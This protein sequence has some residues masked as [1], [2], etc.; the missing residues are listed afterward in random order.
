V[1]RYY[2]KDVIRSPPDRPLANGGD[3]NKEN[4]G[5]GAVVDVPDTEPDN[6][7]EY[8][9]LPPHRGYG[10]LEQVNHAQ[11]VSHAVL[12]RYYDVSYLDIS[13]FYDAWQISWTQGIALAPKR[14]R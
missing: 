8:D 6:D 13:G 4:R 1:R 14:L 11:T 9:V 12:A 5:A 10:S 3:A 2:R 7:D